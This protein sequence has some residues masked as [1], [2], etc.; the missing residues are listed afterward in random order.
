MVAFL[1][2]FGAVP[3]TVP[4]A[5]PDAPESSAFRFCGFGFAVLGGLPGVVEVC[6][7]GL[8]ARPVLD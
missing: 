8:P 6:A 3:L 5:F 7:R 2:F 4:F 1:R